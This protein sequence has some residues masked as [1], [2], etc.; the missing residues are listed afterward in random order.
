MLG[1]AQG[2][3]RL[4]DYDPQWPVLATA[5]CARLRDG[6]GALIQDL[7]HIGSTAVSALP[8]KPILDLALCVASADAFPALARG[9]AG[10]GYVAKGEHG[11]PGRQF[12]TLGEPVTHHVHAV[13]AGSPHWVMWLRFRD[14]LRRHTADRRAYAD[15]KRRLAAAHPRDRSAYTKGKDELVR[16]ILARAQVSRERPG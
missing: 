15:C 5:E 1:V 10:L 13:A 9:L 8:S 3:V 16:A 4:A 6:L 7:E 14:H 12:F 2:T 11:L